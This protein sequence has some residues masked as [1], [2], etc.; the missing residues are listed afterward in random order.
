VINEL[1]K[2]IDIGLCI[3]YVNTKQ[4]AE[5]LAE[6]MRTNGFQVG[7]IHADLDMNHRTMI[8]KTFREGVSRILISTDLLARGIDVQQCNLV[9]NYD[10]PTNH[11]NYIHRIG[12]GGRFGRKGT[13]IN[14]ILTKDKELLQKIEEHYSTQIEEL[15]ENLKEI[16]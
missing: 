14:L 1:F 13:A 6:Y 8:M 16:M 11:E 2:E 7:V 4:R 3:I 9:I 12:R 5:V 15:P 10:L